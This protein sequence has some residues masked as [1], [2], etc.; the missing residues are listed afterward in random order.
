MA[1]AR[2]SRGL[3]PGDRGLARALAD[4]RGRYRPLVSPVRGPVHRSEPRP[5]GRRL[6]LVPAPEPPLARLLLAG[7]ATLLR[8]PRRA[9]LRRARRAA[10]PPGVPDLR[11]DS[12]HPAGRPVRERWAP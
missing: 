9:R 8:D 2:I 1:S 3:R 11:A 12:G 7:P 10:L 4:R 5:A 6:L